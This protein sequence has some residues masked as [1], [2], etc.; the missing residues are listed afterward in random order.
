MTQQG[1][2]GEAALIIFP[3]VCLCGSTTAKMEGE[4]QRPPPTPFDPVYAAL[5]SSWYRIHVWI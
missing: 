2:E 5:G 3:R 1:R 4:R